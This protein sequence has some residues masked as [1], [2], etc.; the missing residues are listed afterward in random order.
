VSSTCHGQWQLYA[1]CTWQSNRSQYVMKPDNGWESRFCL[2]HLHSTPR[3]GKSPSEHCHC[4]S[5]CF[6][7]TRMKLVLESEKIV[8]MCLFVQRN[9]RTW[10]TDRQTDGGTDGRKKCCKDGKEDV[11]MMSI[12]NPSSL[13]MSVRMSLLTGVIYWPV[14]LEWSVLTTWTSVQSAMPS[15]RNKLSQYYTN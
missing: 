7:K 3:S 1:Y 6:G 9:P 11:N 4:R 5:V 10:Q 14:Q 15:V 8:K 13:R 2:A 12:A